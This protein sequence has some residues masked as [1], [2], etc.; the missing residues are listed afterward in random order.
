MSARG[1]VRVGLLAALAACAI[2]SGTLAQDLVDTTTTAP[3]D[4][5][6]GQYL[7]TLRDSTNLYFGST[8]APV[9]TAGLD[10]ALAVGLAHPMARRLPARLNVALGPWL[11]FNRVDGPFYGAEA[12]YGRR[13][14]LG[15]L[16]GRLGYAVAADRWLGSGGY[17][18]LFETGRVDWIFR[19]QA[20]RL[21]ASM[22][23]ERADIR[24]AA[25]RGL[26]SGS[27]TRRYLRRDGLDVG[28]E[29]EHQIW[30][31]RL[32]YRDM[33][34]TPLPVTAR[35]S[36]SSSSLTV[37]DNL[38]AL[39]GRAHELG[40]L[41]GARTPWIPFTA[42]AEYLTSS[43][44]LG[45]DFEYRRTRLGLGG[46]IGLGRSFALV[47]Q[48]SYGRLSGSMVPQAAFYLGGSRTLKSLEGGAR[49]GAGLAIAKIEL[50][51][52]PDVLE[53]LR[54]PHP[55]M[56][57]MQLS[58]FAASGAVWGADPYGGPARPGVDWPNREEFLHE[59]GVSVIYRPG[60]PDPSAFIQFGWAWPL[61]PRDGGPRFTVSYTRGVD[62]V[63]SIGVGDGP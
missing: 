44:K 21:T 43:G 8:V 45:S 33:L 40:Y 13:R 23:H 52:L 57:P 48:A 47:P 28:L 38:A 46:D 10:S 30:R 39:R 29:A 24:L 50:H 49:G 17:E 2:A 20:G 19:A 60:I 6:F 5:A 55:A 15:R 26:I 54:I 42:E 22:D 56:L 62:L 59:A 58:A 7:G 16:D 61:G 53:L 34:E 36:I 51:E 1:F 27:D 37:A 11:S 9:D 18:H 35:W 41:L 3:P 25:I 12:G 4:S 14:G 31:G 63:K 32:S